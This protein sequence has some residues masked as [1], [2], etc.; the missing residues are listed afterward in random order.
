M[1]GYNIGVGLIGLACVLCSATFCYLG[2]Q[3][4]KYF[5]IGGVACALAFLSSPGGTE[6]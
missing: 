1:K 5:L 2:H 3:C 6:E 4:W